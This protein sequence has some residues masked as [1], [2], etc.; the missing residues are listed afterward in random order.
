MKHSGQ[1]NEQGRALQKSTQPAADSG[2]VGKKR[3]E[4]VEHDV[5]LAIRKITGTRTDE[6]ADRLLQQAASALVWPKLKEQGAIITTVAVLAEMAP[7]NA[8]EAMLSVQM[9][10]ANEA[11]LLFLRRAVENQHTEGIDANVLRATRLMRVFNEQLEAMQK[12]K[13]KAGQQKVT[14][15]HVHVHEGGQAIVG[16]VA[17]TGPRRRVGKTDKA[18]HEK[19][20]G[21]LKSGNPPGDFSKGA[22]CGAKTRRGTH[23]QCPAMVNGRCRLH[24]GLSTGPRTPEGR[25]RSRRGPLQHGRYAAAAK[26]ERRNCRN[27]LKEC[28]AMLADIQRETC[29]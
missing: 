11:A 25:E 22:R 13:G 26:A 8:T 28:R 20:R 23:C 5:L 19:R 1:N 17:P 6:A 29:G 16:T 12:L 9:I 21:W 15:E 10:A 27:L 7:Q 18:P 24:G 14:V 3:R 2:V 4:Q